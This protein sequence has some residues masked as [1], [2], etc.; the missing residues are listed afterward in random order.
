MIG[1][2]SIANNGQV[3]FG[4]GALDAVADALRQLSMRRLV[5]NQNNGHVRLG[6]RPQ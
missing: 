4:F 5:F 1:T 2:T 6:I 3:R